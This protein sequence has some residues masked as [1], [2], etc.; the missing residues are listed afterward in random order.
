MKRI[1]VFLLLVMS[2]INGFAQSPGPVAAMPLS[3]AER[4]MAQAQKLIDKNPKDFEAYNALALALSR[5]AR[6]TSDVAFYAKAEEALRKSFAIS[7]ANF[8]GERIHV[9]LLLGK[10]E[11]AAA[12]DAARKLNQRMPD[13]VMVYG[14]LTD[15]NVELGNYK[16]AESAT[17]W[18][19]DLKPGNMPGLT[20]AAYLREL[21][22]DIDGSLELMSM[23]YESTPPTE[24]EDGAWV[25][26]QMAHLTLATGNI[27]DAESLSQ[28]ALAMF[29]GYHYALGNLAKVR[30]Q[31]KRYT[32][33]VDLL[34]QRYQS[35]PH[36]E[37]LFE[38]AQALQLA[39]QME[40]AEKA[41][42]EFERKSLL[43]TNRADNSNH[44][45]I[46]YYADYAKQPLRALEVAQREYARRHDVFTL[47][48][49]AWALHLNSRNE[50]AR[51]QITSAL[52]VGIRDARM[53]WHAGEIMLALGD[54][55]TAER[56][57]RQSAELHTAGSEEASATLAR[58][59]QSSSCARL[60]MTKTSAGAS[61]LC[62]IVV[63]LAMTARSQTTPLRSISGV[64]VTEKNEPVAGA[65][66]VAEY[67]SGRK[68]I[69]TDSNGAFRLVVPSEAVTLTV[70][71]K[72][73]I[74]EDKHLDTSESAANLRLQVSYSIPPVHESMVISASALNPQLTS[75]MTLFTRAHSSPATTR[76]LTRWRRG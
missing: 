61:C 52:G 65:T 54:R 45:L 59:D 15:A 73:L 38:L 16:D 69:V 31:Q 19:L 75:A 18:M 6:E 51:Q 68:E 14:F 33:A 47:D 58:L 28:K 21:F 50:E 4:S 53:L 37:N 56:Y 48:C 67:S 55:L 5:R 30:V 25:V 44:E 66:V 27:Q 40:E 17:Q 13:D 64:V 41:F 57:L 36:A 24:V 10:H 29:P 60:A 72:Y 3:P 42:A 35:A 1:A 62:L 9:W 11:F 49:Y 43:E 34:K 74:F 32:E 26:N 76:S 12:L 23:A 8:D 70:V 46:F 2:A 22:G 39:G 20:R 7:P 63:F 71:G